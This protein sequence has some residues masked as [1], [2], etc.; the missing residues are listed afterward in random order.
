MERACA[1]AQRA[2]RVV[3]RGKWRPACTHQLWHGGW[4]RREVAVAVE[5]L[6]RHF[7]F[8]AD[9]VQSVRGRGPDAA[10]EVGLQGHGKRGRIALLSAA[11]ALCGRPGHVTKG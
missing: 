6:A 5:L 3:A 4:H 2:R 1:D 10:S 7:N 9:G 8:A 11:R